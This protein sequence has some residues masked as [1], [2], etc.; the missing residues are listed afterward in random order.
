MTKYILIFYILLIS[1]SCAKKKSVAPEENSIFNIKIDTL[2]IHKNGDLTKVALFR[3]NFYCMFETS[4]MNTSQQFIKMF[5]INQKGK[6]IE[7][8]FVPNEIQ[9]MPHYKL[10]VE[11]DSLYV[12]ETQFEEKNFVL[13]EYVADLTLT[14]K[15]NFKIFKD[16]DYTI[17]S[18]CNG[19]FGGTIFFQNIKTKEVYEASSACPIIVNKIN[20]DYFITNNLMSSSS[21]L[22]ISDPSKLK[23]SKLDLTKR[24]GSQYNNGIQILLDVYD[25]DV[26]TSFVVN[27][28][29]YHIYSDKTNTYIGVIEKGKIKP[30]Y[31]FAFKFF[32]N[33]NQNL[34]NGKQ[35]LNF[36]NPVNKEN[37]ILIIDNMNIDFHVLK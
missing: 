5:V 14:K 37:G 29:L 2:N 3:N 25:L 1:I 31:K 16:N 20:K 17:Y 11:N 23:K 10:I 36:Y 27:N 26:E 13:G 18:D 21:I 8:V 4:R 35:I 33:L 22:K 32:T 30:I 19:E 6:F 15:K 24:Q 28:K 34:E 12:K 7:D 9:N